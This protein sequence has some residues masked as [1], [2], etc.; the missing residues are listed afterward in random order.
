M[1]IEKHIT[2]ADKLTTLYGSWPTFH[3]AEILNLDLWRGDLRP[4]KEI[5]IFPTLTVKVHLFIEH[6]ASRETIATLRF[7]SVENLKLEEFNYQNAILSLEIQ[8]DNERFRPEYP[9]FHVKIDGAFGLKASFHCSE[10][11]VL[12]ASLIPT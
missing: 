11:Q 1:P 5:Y 8:K 6:P 9:I 7:T 10:I 12:D 2:N 3:D 4:E